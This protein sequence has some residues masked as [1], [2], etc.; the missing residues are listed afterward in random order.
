MIVGKAPLRISFVGGGLDLPEVFRDE[1]VYLLGSAI[2]KFVYVAINPLSVF[3]PERI[4]F[5]YRKTESRQ[6]VSELERPVARAAVNWKARSRRLNIAT[7]ADLPGHSGLGSSSAFTVALLA[8]LAGIVGDYVDAS[9]LWRDAVHLERSM[10]GEVGGWQDQVQSTFGGFRLYRFYRDDVTS[11]RLRLSDSRIQFLSRAMRLRLVGPPRQSYNGGMS[12]LPN[13]QRNANQTIISDLALETAR[14]ME[15]ATSDEEALEALAS[16][17]R[18]TWKWKHNLIKNGLTTEIGDLRA[19]KD[20]SLLGWK[21]CGNGKSGFV[22]EIRSP[23]SWPRNESGLYESLN[24][25]AQ[26]VSVSLA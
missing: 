21:L 23:S 12:G 10:L 17:V 19:N 15:T 20:A 5:T 7:M 24:L 3:A 26:G 9:S 13:A 6:H 16:A 2:N 1:P 18:F 22:L 25:D 11:E 4:R 14:S 8:G